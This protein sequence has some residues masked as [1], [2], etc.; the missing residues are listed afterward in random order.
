MSYGGRGGFGGG[1]GGGNMQNLMKQAKMMQENMQKA[2]QELEDAEL[3]GSASGGLV[4]VKV[5]GTKKISS[6]TINKDAVDPDD[7]E[8]LE[9]LMMAAIG[10]AYTKADQL[11]AEK[12]GPFAGLGGGLF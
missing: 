8:M 6:I 1:F 3:I 12:M 5:N 9:D 2:Q 10:D 4:T 11:Y 7:V